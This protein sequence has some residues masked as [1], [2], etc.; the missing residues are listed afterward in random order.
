MLNELI[1]LKSF[2]KKDKFLSYNTF[3]RSLTLEVELEKILLAIEEY[4]NQNQEVEEINL[5]ELIVFFYLLNPSLKKKDSYQKIFDKLNTLNINNI[6]SATSRTSVDNNNDK[7][8]SNVINNGSNVNH[9]KMTTMAIMTITMTKH[10]NNI[11]SNDNI[12]P[13]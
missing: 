11:D 2:L 10:C 8:G 7:H 12:L 5:D 9:E 3:F 1:I 13:L 4:Y 6:S